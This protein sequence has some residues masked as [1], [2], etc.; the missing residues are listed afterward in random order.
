M[1]RQQKSQ[2]KKINNQVMQNRLTTQAIMTVIEDSAASKYYSP[3]NIFLKQ[4]RVCSRL[5]DQVGC[6]VGTEGP[7]FEKQES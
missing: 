3:S 4:Y 1:K 2:N 6:G 7:S 5:L